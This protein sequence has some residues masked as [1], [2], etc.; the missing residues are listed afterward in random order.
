MHYKHRK[1]GYLMLAVTLIVLALFAWVYIT[2][3]NEP[4]SVDSGPNF[5]MTALMV[6]IVLALAY[7][8]W[9]KLKK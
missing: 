8:T 2:A 7:F 3:A 6:L 9:R 4:P 5:V 1:I